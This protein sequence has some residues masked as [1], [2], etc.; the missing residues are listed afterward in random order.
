MIL[1]KTDC[2]I[3]NDRVRVTGH[4]MVLGAHTGVHRHTN[5][6]IMV[7]VTEDVCSL[8]KTAASQPPSLPLA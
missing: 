3:E 8:W 7:P 4:K 2:H 5:D 1:E 6:Y